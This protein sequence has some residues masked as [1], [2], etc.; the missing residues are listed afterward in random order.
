MHGPLVALA[1]TEFILATGCATDL[2][3]L[4]PCL[5]AKVLVKQFHHQ[6][7]LPLMSN[8]WFGPSKIAI[9]FIIIGCVLAA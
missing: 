8:P 1:G 6:L 4:K 9:Y 7:T 2:I 3:M 5:L